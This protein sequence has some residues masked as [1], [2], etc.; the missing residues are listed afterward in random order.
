M[1]S[2]PRLTQLSTEHQARTASAPSKFAPSIA[3]SK[4]RRMPGQMLSSD[5]SIERTF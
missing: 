2:E 1:V 4:T 3:T 5:M